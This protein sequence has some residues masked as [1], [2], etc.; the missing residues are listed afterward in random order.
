MCMHMHKYSMEE[1]AKM[2]KEADL[3][4]FTCQ[5]AL[6]EAGELKPDSPDDKQFSELE[7]RMGALHS[8]CEHHLGGAK[9]AR[10]RFQVGPSLGLGLPVRVYAYSCSRLRPIVQ[11]R[12]LK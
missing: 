8:A 1:L 10:A 3:F 5:E 2:V 6:A 9:Q 11:D 4:I 12:R 7:S